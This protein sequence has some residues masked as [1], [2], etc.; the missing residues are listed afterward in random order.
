MT[1]KEKEQRLR[2]FVSSLSEADAREQLTLAYLQME[3]C[4]QVMQG[5]DVEPV[6]MMENGLDSDL[7]LF[8][9]CKKLYMES[10]VSISINC[11]PGL[12]GARSHSIPEL[13]IKIVK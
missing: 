11:K 9:M 1:E 12:S 10:N 5:E 2:D 3:R 7:E 4:Q 8:Y 6:T 13:V